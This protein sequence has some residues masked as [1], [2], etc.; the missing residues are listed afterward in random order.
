MQSLHW[1]IFWFKFN[2]TE[3]VHAYKSFFFAILKEAEI[4]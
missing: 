2:N 3:T 4:I 1:K